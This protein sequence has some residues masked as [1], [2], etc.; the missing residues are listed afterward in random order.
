M[1]RD[2]RKH[3]GKMLI[4]AR[5]HLHIQLYERPL[6][7]RMG[8]QLVIDIKNII[9]FVKCPIDMKKGPQVVIW[10]STI[11][12]VLRALLVGKVALVHV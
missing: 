2:P 11:I 5:V 9:F 12:S 3:L 8:P 6:F 10:L 4:S 7:V 1:K